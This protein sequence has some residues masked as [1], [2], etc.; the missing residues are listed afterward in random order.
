M[1]GDNA[2]REFQRAAV[3]E[4]WDFGPNE[5]REGQVNSNIHR[6]H[7]KPEGWETDP[8]H[9]YTLL[10]LTK[11]SEIQRTLRF[12]VEGQQLYSHSEQP[13]RRLRLTAAHCGPRA[14]QPR[15]WAGKPLWLDGT[16]EC[17]PVTCC[18]AKASA[19]GAVLRSL[20]LKPHN[21]DNDSNP[22]IVQWVASGFTVVFTCYIITCIFFTWYV[23]ISLCRFHI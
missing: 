15:Q 13:M 2:I 17:C 10:S 12:W 21:R 18:Q 11:D 20:P 4:L 19:S 3:P 6:P 22:P 14:S 1:V 5:H 8:L 23:A 16:A 9:L 7:Q